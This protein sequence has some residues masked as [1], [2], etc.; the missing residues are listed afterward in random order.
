MA[1]L[2]GL[3]GILEVIMHLESDAFT[4]TYDEQACSPAIVLNRI[5]KLGYEPELASPKVPEIVIEFRK[6]KALPE[7]VMS[8]LEE[9]SLSGKPLLIDFFASWCAPCKTMEKEIFENPELERT[10]GSVRIMKVDT[11]RS[12]ALAEHFGIKALPSLIVLD[13]D[14]E[15]ILRLLGALT[16]QEFAEQLA[17][18]G[19]RESETG[20]SRQ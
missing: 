2:E 3:E 12:P 17:S 18:I 16:A 6:E 14:G 19:T 9:A 5:Q 15:E 11:D 4:V 13:E 10:L 20:G 7:A 8:E 1:A